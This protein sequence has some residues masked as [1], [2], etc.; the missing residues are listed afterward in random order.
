MLNCRMTKS[1]LCRPFISFGKFFLWIGL[2]SA[3][4]LAQSD[5]GHESEL[6]Q[7]VEA[8]KRQLADTQK[9]LNA[10]HTQLEILEQKVVTLEGELAA[11]KATEQTTATVATLADAVSKLQEEQEAQQSEIQVH[12]QT[13]VETASRFPFKISG[14]VLFNANAIDGAVNDTTL[15]VLAISRN[16]STANGSLSATMSQTILGFEASGPKIWGARTYGDLQADF[17]AQQT[18][19]S[20]YLAPS[21]ILRLRTAGV[22]LDWPKTTL[23]AGLLP[24]ILS[25]NS[26]SSYVTVAAP[27]MTW[28]GNLWAWL[29]QLT[30]SQSFPISEQKKFSLKGSLLDVPD[31]VIDYGSSSTTTTTTD[32]STMTFN[33]PYISAG[34]HSRY[35]GIALRGG[36]EWNNA[37]KN[38]IG[39]GGYFSPHSY[40]VNGHIYA[41]A[42]TVDWFF[43]LPANISF[44]G[45]FY[46]G[47]G[48]GGLN[49]GNYKD[50]V[51]FYGLN[52][53]GIMT[54][55]YHAFHDEGGWS[56]LG[57]R[58]NNRLEFNLAFGEDS[59]N[60]NQLRQSAYAESYSYLGLIRNQT[61]LA[62][63]IYRPHSSLV[64]S[65]EYRK[66]NSWQISGQKN[67][68]Q[69]F[70]L[71]AGYQF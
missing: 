1:V 18:S 25:P 42:A 21:G 48:L 63:I 35:P 3:S 49:D 7:Q 22:Q 54:T 20:A 16:S 44:S 53:Y 71:A 5:T 36:Y 43:S 37:H 61:T 69:I 57:W 15:P 2:I 62:N 32:T 14:L 13:K 52:E 29:P 34:E 23:Q 10:Y 11:S 38:S 28:S 40:G 17:F 70:G 67:Q 58:A 64:F 41:Q 31:P 8:M 39:I 9:Q 60:T 56:Q 46:N 27:A 66:L 51:P 26:P 55:A 12:E 65:T 68:A 30:L 47:S 50:V 45:Q 6:L 19:S 33:P 24:L 4:A 59:G